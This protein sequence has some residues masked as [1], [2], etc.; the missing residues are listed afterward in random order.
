MLI[1]PQFSTFTFTLPVEKGSSVL[2]IPVGS[3]RTQTTITGPTTWIA[4]L[5]AKYPVRGEVYAGVDQNDPHCNQSMSFEPAHLSTFVQYVT[6]LSENQ[7]W[8]TY[9]NDSKGDIHSQLAFIQ[10]LVLYHKQG[11]NISLLSDP[12]Y[13][14]TV[15]ST[16]TIF[17]TFTGPTTIYETIT[18]WLS[19][20]WSWLNQLAGSANDVCGGLCGSC[21]I[22]YPEV[23]IYYW[24]V[25]SPNTACI[26]TNSS[27]SYQVSNQN[28]SSS[29]FKLHR[30]GLSKATAEVSTL[31]NSDGFTL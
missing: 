6:T 9:M 19:P 21:E 10:S 28:S 13:Q 15:T 20:G 27:S 7:I 12:Y 16:S 4:T 26:Q 1:R 23:F 31:V 3:F 8:S 11:K 17:T 18:T 22:F 14:T 5:T 25:T 24:P 2:D 29:D 30:R